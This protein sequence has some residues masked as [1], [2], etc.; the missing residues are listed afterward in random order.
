[1]G[2]T[3]AILLLI[4]L[5]LSCAG[6]REPVTL[7][8]DDPA[9]KIRAIAAAVRDSDRAAVPQLIGELESDDPAIRFYAIGALQ[10]LTGQTLGYH[11]FADETERARAVQR[12]RD[13]LAERE[14]DS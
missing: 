4:P 9:I 12:W 8:S 1:M 2:R 7:R 6:P 3:V 5:V 10:R 11:Y 13:W 14:R